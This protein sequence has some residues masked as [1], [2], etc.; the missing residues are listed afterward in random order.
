MKHEELQAKAQTLYAKLGGVGAAD[1]RLLR[2]L[3]LE[4]TRARTWIR[5]EGERTDQC[6]YDIL[7]EICVGCRCGRVGGGGAPNESSSA[8][9][10]TKR[11]D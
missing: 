8:T 4:L 7:G 2:A 3:I 9:A 5:A 11:P 6:T 1:A 10:A